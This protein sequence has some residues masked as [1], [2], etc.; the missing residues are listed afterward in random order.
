MHPPCLWVAVSDTTL[1]LFEMFLYVQVLSSEIN[2]SI[3]F[4][5]KLATVAPDKV[6]ATLLLEAWAIFT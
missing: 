1:I 3:Q 5:F 4:D 6:G 2:N